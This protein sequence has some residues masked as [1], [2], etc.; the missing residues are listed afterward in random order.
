M[1]ATSLLTMSAT[2]ARATEAQT[3][4]GYDKCYIPED[5]TNI[6][7]V[8]LIP[9]VQAR[10]Q[11]LGQ[12]GSE[13]V[14]QTGAGAPV[15][16]DQQL[17]MVPGV[18]L[19]RRADSR[20]AHPTTQGLSMRGIGANG[21]GRVLVTLDGVPLN[22]PFGG[23]VNWSTFSSLDVAEMEVLRGGRSGS[24]GSQALSGRVNLRSAAFHKS[25]NGIHAWAGSNESISAAG[26]YAT[27]FRG[28]ELAVSAGF[29]DGDGD[30]L[31]AEE[32]RGPVD[33]RAANDAAYLAI[34]SQ[35]SIDEVELIAS[36]RFFEEN[37]LNG[38]SLAANGTSGMDA[39]VTLQGGHYRTAQWEIIAHYRE[40]D[41]TNIFASARDDRTTERAVLDQFDVPAWGA[42]VLARVQ[43]DGVELGMDGRRMS[44]ETNERFRNLGAGFT[45][46]RRAG[47]DQWT[48]GFYGEYSHDADWGALSATLRYDRWRTYN[49]V[50]DEFNIE[51]GFPGFAS[52]DRSDLVPNRK[53]GEWTG[54]VGF[55]RSLTGAIDLRAA[56]YK[57]WRLPTLN[58][59]YRPF[60]VVNDITEANPNLT[61]ETLYGLEVGFD[62]EPLNTV[63]LSATYYRNWLRDGV[64][65][66]TIGFGPGFFP[67][68][69]FVPEGGVL[70]QRA[71]VDESITDGIELDARLDWNTH[72]TLSASYLYARARITKFDAMSDLVG[73][74][75][76]QTPRHSATVRAAYD[77]DD[78]DMNIEGRYAGGQYDDDL[79]SRRLDAI[80]TINVGARYQL[81]DRFTLT[82]QAENLFDAKVV[83]A[84]TADGLET[85]AQ[86][87]F[88][89]VGLDASF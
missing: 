57:T 86:R 85:L 14:L 73:K 76:V 42:G 82:A 9:V 74:R 60:R 53:G 50:R 21:A 88:W 34:T 62:Y 87:R 15:R 66:V 52:P 33:R 8:T 47:G 32:D 6:T 18:G 31:L 44:G 30:Y 27:D 19:F 16:L 89:R 1:A 80:F 10:L 17:A 4:E 13:Q 28:G 35:L 75:P 43:F 69:G 5:C 58:E 25:H 48:L 65:N 61:P 68:G 23:W 2:A 67:L 11:R 38:L 46:Q 12:Q 81:S 70:R 84:V 51:D 63:K 36:L 39:S 26:R 49:G 40:R 24:F 54:R 72:W 78:W 79:N 83:S 55:E 29:F 77:G 59:Y 37:R 22:D 64:G 41:F 3:V 45:R 56:A 71:N 7:D 20:T